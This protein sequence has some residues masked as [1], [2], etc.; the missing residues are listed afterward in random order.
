[1]VLLRQAKVVSANDSISKTEHAMQL[2]RV[3][4]AASVQKLKDVIDEKKRVR[5]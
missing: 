1:V 5:M 4:Q 3:E 2:L